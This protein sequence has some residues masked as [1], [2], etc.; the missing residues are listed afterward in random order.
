LRMDWAGVELE[1]GIIR[2]EKVKKN[3]GEQ[4]RESDLTEDLVAELQQWGNIDGWAGP[5]N[6]HRG[7]SRLAT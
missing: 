4:W 6:H 7:K 5:I 3:R 2:H 1:R